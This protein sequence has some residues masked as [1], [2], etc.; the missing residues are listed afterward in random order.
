MRYIGSLLLMTSPLQ[1]ACR[2]AFRN[3]SRIPDPF[4]G[5]VGPL[6]RFLGVADQSEIGFG[7]RSKEMFK[8]YMLAVGLVLGGMSASAQAGDCY[9]WK[10]VCTYECVTTYVCKQVPYTKTVCTYDHCGNPIYTE[11]T[12]YKTVEAPVVKKVPVTKWVKVYHG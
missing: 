10:K 9:T 5:I 1:L 4:I 3:A 8:K 11:K 6:R 12:F 2:M 7:T